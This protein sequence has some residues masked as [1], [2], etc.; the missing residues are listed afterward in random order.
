[1]TFSHPIPAP[2]QVVLAAQVTGGRAFGIGKDGTLKASMR[3]HWAD[4]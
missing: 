1:M 2:C 4:H 3:A